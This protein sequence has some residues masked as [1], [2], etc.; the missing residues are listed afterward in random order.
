MGQS[1][2]L[3]VYAEQHFVQW[4]A[5][6]AN[7]PK[8]GEPPAGTV[9]DHHTQFYVGAGVKSQVFVGVAST[10]PTEP[11]PG[12]D[13]LLLKLDGNIFRQWAQ[14]LG[15]ILGYAAFLI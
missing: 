12:L 10:L 2:A 4:L 15:T 9:G 6:A 11:S 1:Q 13:L 8:N 7:R 14:P 5:N 3:K